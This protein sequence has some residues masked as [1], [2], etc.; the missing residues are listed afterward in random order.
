LHDAGDAYG[1]V[2][3]ALVD[4]HSQSRLGVPGVDADDGQPSLFSSVH[5]HVD[6]APVSSPIR[7]TCGA[8]SDECCD[9]F[10]IRMNHSFTLNLSCR[11]TT[12]IA[13]SFRDTS[14]PT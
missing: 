6:V 10:R 8:F 13:V 4:L 7:A 9:R 11:S 12:Q 14:S 3:V 1:I 5:S 2:A